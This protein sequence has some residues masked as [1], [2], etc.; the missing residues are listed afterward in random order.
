MRAE[1]GFDL[2]VK[3]AWISREPAGVSY[4]RLTVGSTR[5]AELCCVFT[6]CNVE[7]ASFGLTIGV[8]RAATADRVVPIFPWSTCRQVSA[9]FHPCWRIR[10]T[11]PSGMYR[12]TIPEP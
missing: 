1:I 10:A 2:R 11:G 12:A 7:S 8:E 4:S 9:K 5:L 3:E 6:G